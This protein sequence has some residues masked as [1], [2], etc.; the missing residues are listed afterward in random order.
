MKKE[1]EIAQKICY[2][3]IFIPTM[4]LPE[5]DVWLMLVIYTLRQLPC[6]QVHK[7]V[8]CMTYYGHTQPSY[9]LIRHSSVKKN[10]RLLLGRRNYSVNSYLL[11]SM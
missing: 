6:G 2:Y 11:N 3:I 7:A 9:I 5:V 8:V 1:N 10:W 4:L